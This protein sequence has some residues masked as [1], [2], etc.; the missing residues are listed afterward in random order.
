VANAL[1]SAEAAAEWVEMWRT[2]AERGSDEWEAIEGGQAGMHEHD[3]I[4]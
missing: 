2:G 4:L 3:A 1:R